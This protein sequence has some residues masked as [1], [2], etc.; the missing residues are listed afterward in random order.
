METKWCPR[1]HC[2]VTD[3]GPSRIADYAK[4]WRDGRCYRCGTALTPTDKATRQLT[5]AE[6]AE[7][8]KIFDALQPKKDLAA[9]DSLAKNKLQPSQPRDAGMLASPPKALRRY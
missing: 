7:A 3:P 2:V 9:F 6:L 4:F 5:A 1:C 8:R